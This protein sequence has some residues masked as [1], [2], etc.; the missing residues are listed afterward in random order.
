MCSL[1]FKN[2]G[3]DESDLV[4]Q[5]LYVVNTGDD[6]DD[7]TDAVPVDG[8]DYLRRVIK[9]RKRCP[10][11]VTASVPVTAPES[12][13]ESSSRGGNI[14]RKRSKLAPPTGCC[15]APAWQRQQV[16]DFS[17]VR[18]KLAQHTS[19]LKSGG[20]IAAHN[21]KTPDKKKEGEWCRFCLG[22]KIWEK[23]KETREESSETEEDSCKSEERTEGHDPLVDVIATL[24]YHVVETVLEYHVTWLRAVGWT[25]QFGPWLYSLLA[26]L[27]KP[28]T[29]DMGSLI[30]DLALLC[31]EERGKIFSESSKDNEVENV[32]NHDLAALNLFVCLVAKYFDQGDLADVDSE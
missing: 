31:A 32:P 21:V 23:V 2:E 19:L 10:D 5:A 13:K 16:A 15:P 1:I 3:L 8:A 7:D 20:G 6:I 12:R 30:R 9:E 27:E 14:A 4:K 26:R 29:P 18:Q 11:T 25:R 28:L 24:P 17:T 22:S